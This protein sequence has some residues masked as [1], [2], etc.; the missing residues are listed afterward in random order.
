MIKSKALEIF[1]QP[2]ARLNC[3]QS[4]IHAYRAV[5]KDGHHNVEDFK[6]FGGGRAPEGLCGALFAACS[7]HPLNAEGLTEHFSARM[8]S[9]TCKDLKSRA[10][11]CTSCVAAASELLEESLKGN[12]PG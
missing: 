7:A 8:G 10:V 9:V 5:A 6:D 12:T 1:R 4:V 3:A 11:P 2:P